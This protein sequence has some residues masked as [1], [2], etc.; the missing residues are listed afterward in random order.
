MLRNSAYNYPDLKCLDLEVLWNSSLQDCTPKPSDPF[1]RF[2]G[3]I[4][5]YKFKKENL[6][7]SYTEEILFFEKSCF[8]YI[9][10]IIVPVTVKN[11]NSGSLRSE[12]P[13]STVGTGGRL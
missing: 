8:S 12:Y 7:Y 6:R 9:I 13:S 11:Y 10:Y 4:K 2:V 3:N 1:H 5:N